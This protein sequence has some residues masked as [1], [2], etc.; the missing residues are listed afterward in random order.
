MTKAK[1]KKSLTS[2]D[3]ITFEVLRSAFRDLC[4]QGSAMIERIA[5][6]PA[7]TE[8]RDF[9]VSLLTAD[10]RLVAHGTRDHTPHFRDVR[11]HGSKRGRGRGGR[12]PAR[13][14]VHVQ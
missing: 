2:M 14:R 4:T 9:S 13:G 10:G 7:I 11:G 1:K 12:F 8:G 5:Y 3:P 6:A